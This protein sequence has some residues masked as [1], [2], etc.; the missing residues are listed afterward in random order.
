MSILYDG[1]RH[2]LSLSVTLRAVAL[3]R[4]GGRILPLGGGMGGVTFVKPGI[5][6]RP[7][8]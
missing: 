3:L 2:R 6:G 7:V 8:V 1:T 5:S 4:G